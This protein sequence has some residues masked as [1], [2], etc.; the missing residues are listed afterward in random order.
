MSSKFFV[1][2]LK[3]SIGTYYVGQTSDLSRRINMHQNGKGSKYLR[4]FEKLELVY[5][6]EVDSRSSAL[7]IEY[8][9]KKL[10]HSQKEELISNSGKISY[11]LLTN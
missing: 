4:M 8:K 7:K 5:Q 10:S 9:L 3:T 1:Y 2:I 6:K 11:S